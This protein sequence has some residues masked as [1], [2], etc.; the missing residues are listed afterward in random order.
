MSHYQ[1]ERGAYRTMVHHVLAAQELNPRT[2]RSSFTAH[3]DLLAQQSA[4]G[5]YRAGLI[6]RW[7]ALPEFL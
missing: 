3:T 4:I 5:T 7:S 2:H 6:C 1:P